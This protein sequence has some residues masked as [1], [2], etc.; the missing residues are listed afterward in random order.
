M[1]MFSTARIEKEQI[2]G[3]SFSPQEVLSDDSDISTRNYLLRKAQRLGNEFKG[4]V[5]IR[6]QSLQGP[7]EVFT[8]IWDVST[9]YVTLKGGIAIPIHT[10]S[11]VA[12]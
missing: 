6:F 9:N 12:I 1:N 5:L 4:K 8:T 2:K 7:M 3:L 10:I 11:K